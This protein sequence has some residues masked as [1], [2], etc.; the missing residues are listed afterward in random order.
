MEFGGMAYR[1]AEPEKAILDYLYLNPSVRTQQDIDSF[2][3]NRNEF[4]N[5]IDTARLNSYLGIFNSK[6][7]TKRV[8]LITE[9]LIQHV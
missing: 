1:L 9:K 3:L 6:S 8:K 4:E 5:L 2:R 7:L